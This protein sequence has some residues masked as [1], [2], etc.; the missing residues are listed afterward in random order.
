MQ[1]TAGRVIYELENSLKISNV[2]LIKTE[3]SKAEEII[4]DL[5]G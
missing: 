2:K 4:L 5:K 1:K 3:H